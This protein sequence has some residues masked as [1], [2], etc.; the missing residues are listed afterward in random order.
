[1]E[2]V[3]HR[4]PDTD[5]TGI[6]QA[7][8]PVT[9]FA[10]TASLVAASIAFLP[11][12]SS[13]LAFSYTCSTAFPQNGLRRE[14]RSSPRFQ[15]KTILVTGVGTAK[16]LRIARAFYETG[17]KVIGADFEPL[18]VPSS[19]RFSRALS[20]FHHLR[21]PNASS[22]ATLYMR[23]LIRIIEEEDVQLWLS[24]SGIVSSVDDGEAR[25][26]VEHRTRCSTF[27]VDFETASKISDGDE[28]ASYARS[29]GL[30]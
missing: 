9:H 11:L 28:F 22:G 13:I 6:V 25:E 29:I 17:H 1:M 19:G 10:K 21:M 7:P 14:I 5:N 16:G 8:S 23:D 4:L 12:S 2:T 3:A 24:C 27:Q 26:L 20:S 18:G 30:V 15:P